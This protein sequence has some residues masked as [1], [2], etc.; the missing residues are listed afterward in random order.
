[1]YTPSKFT[2]TVTI[3]TY[4]QFEILGPIM[5]ILAQTGAI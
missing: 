5:H 2:P 4:V 3:L 1:M